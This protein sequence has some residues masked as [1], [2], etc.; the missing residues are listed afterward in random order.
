MF[1]FLTTS[2]DGVML[3]TNDKQINEINLKIVPR[4]F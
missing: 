4:A 3:M 2:L 1:E